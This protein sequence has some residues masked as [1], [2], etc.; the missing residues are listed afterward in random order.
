[1]NTELAIECLVAV[2]GLYPPDPVSSVDVEAAR[3]I[4][5]ETAEAVR[6]FF[7]LSKAGQ[8]EKA[9]AISYLGTWKS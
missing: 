8:P 7:D 1:M 9:P 4:P 3:R 5:K 2:T 6:K